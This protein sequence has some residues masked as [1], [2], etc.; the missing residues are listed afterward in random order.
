MAIS[1]FVM[2][3]EFFR[4]SF[5]FLPCEHFSMRGVR[6]GLV[7]DVHDTC[8]K[9]VN[10]LKALYLRYLYNCL[11]AWGNSSDCNLLWDYTHYVI[12]F[13]LTKL[14]TKIQGLYLKDHC[15]FGLCRKLHNPVFTTGNF[16]PSKQISYHLSSSK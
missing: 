15:W 1:Q 8:P 13:F 12:F 2:R 5:W 3:V 11:N 14:L 6:V 7:S 4:V 16:K 9:M 10:P